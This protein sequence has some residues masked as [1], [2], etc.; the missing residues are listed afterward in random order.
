MARTSATTA[1][2]LY[3]Y[4]KAASRRH[5]GPFLEAALSVDGWIDG[6]RERVGVACVGNRSEM[7]E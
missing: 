4:G 5:E 2:V 3:T 7:L 6:W 1:S